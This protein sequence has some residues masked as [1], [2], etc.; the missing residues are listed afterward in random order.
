[1][2]CVTPFVNAEYCEKIE[3]LIESRIDNFELEKDVRK[4]L[5]LLVKMV[6]NFSANNQDAQAT[7]Y[8][9]KLKKYLRTIFIE[10]FYVDVPRETAF[11]G[12]AFF[13]TLNGRSYTSAQLIKE[14]IENLFDFCTQRLDWVQDKTPAL[15]TVTRMLGDLNTYLDLLVKNEREEFGAYIPIRSEK[16]ENA[17]ECR[18]KFHNKVLDTDTLKEEYRT[19]IETIEKS[20]L[21]EI[22]E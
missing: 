14:Y 22:I 16:I 7:L 10:K 19:L 6:V 20:I 1:M 18:E 17:V 8:L 4:N 12:I 11:P 2:A 15:L 13:A 9:K 5:E 3:S 21:T